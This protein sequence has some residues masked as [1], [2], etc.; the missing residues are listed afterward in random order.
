MNFLLQ[1]CGRQHSFG[2]SLYRTNSLPTEYILHNVAPGV[3]IHS[4]GQLAISS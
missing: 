1:S 4:G 3:S 2:K